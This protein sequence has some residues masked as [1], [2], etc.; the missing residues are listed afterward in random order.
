MRKVRQGY[1]TEDDRHMNEFIE[2][3]DAMVEYRGESMDGIGG[4]L[5]DDP[6]CR[7]CVKLPYD[8]NGRPCMY[9]SACHGE[10][11]WIITKRKWILNT[12]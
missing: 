1:I 10:R 3:E 7:N 5:M 12:Q 9:R 4:E 6:Q 2:G 8:S 11:K